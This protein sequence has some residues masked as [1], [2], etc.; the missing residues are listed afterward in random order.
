MGLADIIRELVGHKKKGKRGLAKRAKKRT[1]RK[2]TKKIKKK[3]RKK[4]K[5]KVQKRPA[6]KLA[7]KL[8]KVV[9][10]PK[11]EPEEKEVGLVTHYFRKISVG[12]IKLKGTLNLGDKIHIKGA[13]DDF[14]QIVRSMQLDHKDIS[15][16]KKG[17]EVGI[18][19]TQ[20]VHDNDKVYRIVRQ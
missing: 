14:T 19:V 2:P 11:K 9:P 5:R 12:A 4:I 17:V 3:P 18:E 7:K 1:I 16:A 20:R 6:R 13:H 15:L 8:H 10:K